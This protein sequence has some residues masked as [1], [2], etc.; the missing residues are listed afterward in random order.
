MTENI[1]RYRLHM[2]QPNPWFLLIVWNISEIIISYRNIENIEWNFGNGATVDGL[3]QLSARAS[4]GIALQVR[5]PYIHREGTWR[6]NDGY[7]GVRLVLPHLCE[8]YRVPV[9]FVETIHF[10]FRLQV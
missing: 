10:C 1:N 2:V 4:A 3:A 5:G 6:V 8:W 9:T 7:R